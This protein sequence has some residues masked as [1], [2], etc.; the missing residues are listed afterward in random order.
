MGGFGVGGVE[1]L[2]H[3]GGCHDC[4]WDDL[5]CFDRK[6]VCLIVSDVCESRAVGKFTIE[7]LCASV[8]RKALALRMYVAAAS[9]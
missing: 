2:V 3:S 8:I 5:M 9:S 7:I 6:D 4:V 1:Y